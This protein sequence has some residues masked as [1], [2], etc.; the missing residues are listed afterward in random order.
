MATFR[1]NP[2]GIAEIGRTEAMQRAMG[3]FAEKVRI[4]A[5][6]IAPVDTGQ[7]AFDVSTP[8]G[9]E[10]GFEV[11]TG[12]RDG[13]AYGRVTNRSSN[14]GYCYAEALEFGNSQMAAQRPLGRALDAVKGTP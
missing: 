9:E 10:G 14:N 2:A 1:G 11:S 12:V 5:E 13:K 8:P 7:Y 4:V 6:A 3:V